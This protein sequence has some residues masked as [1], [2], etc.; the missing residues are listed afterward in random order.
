MSLSNIQAE[1]AEIFFSDDE[2]THLLQPAHNMIIYRNNVTTTL[3]R[4]LLDIYP[5]IA[6]LVGE[7]FF[8][9]AAKEYI[10]RYPSRSSNLHDYGEYFSDFLD[11]YPPVKNLIYLA[12]V[13]K[14]EWACHLLHF[15]ADHEAFNLQ[16]LENIPQDQYAHLHFVLHPAS[17]IMQC[18]YPLLRIIDLCKNEIDG[19]IDITEAGINL[20]IIRRDFEIR[21]VPLTVAEFTFL[22]ALRDNKTLSEALDAAIFHD[23]EFKLDEKLPAWIQDKTIVDCFIPS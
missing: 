21:L 20:L 4:T 12:Q 10:Q 6:R 13:A 1:F 7:D 2:D 16:L 5:M 22:E 3:I 9:T 17:H 14:F 19:I 15:A 23:S 11:E 8:H 18:H